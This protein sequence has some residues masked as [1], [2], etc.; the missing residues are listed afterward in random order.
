MSP[1]EALDFAML[2][3]IEQHRGQ[4]DKAGEPYILHVLRVGLAGKTREE[5]IVGVLH[6]IVE[7]T[8]M[9]IDRLSRVFSEDIVSGVDAVTRRDGESY[10]DFIL[11]AYQHPVGRQVKMNDLRDNMRPDRNRNPTPADK[12]RFDKY[13]RAYQVL[14]DTVPKYRL[15]S[16]R[17][18]REEKEELPSIEA[19][20]KEAWAMGE[21]G[22]EFGVPICIEDL[23]ENIVV[24][25]AKLS[26][27]VDEQEKKYAEERRERERAKME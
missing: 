13:D 9:T 15:V 4:V 14:T 3:A 1:N 2:L 25:A 18:F 6:D 7:D 10:E 22:W 20:V 21:N 23:E 24:D 16:K 27:L 8:V 11:R 26:D 17:Y 19:A 12:E 5:Q